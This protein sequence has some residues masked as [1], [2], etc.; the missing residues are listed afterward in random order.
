MSLNLKMKPSFSAPLFASVL[1]LLVLASDF[2]RKSLI[3]AGG[4][5]YLSVIIVQ[6]LIFIIPS[7]VFCRL[8]GVGYAS[9]LNIRLISPNKLG[10][11][12]TATLVLIFGSMLIR[13][14]QIYLF[15]MSSFTYSVFQ[16]YVGAGT[17]YNFLFAATAF[18]V[19]PALTE[20]FAFR[21]IILTEYNEGGYGA[22]NATVISSLLCS[23]LFFSLESLPIRF[24]TSL[25]F[26][27]L[28]YVTGSSL[29]SLICH[30]CFNIYSVFGEK[31]IIKALSDPSN[32]VI[33]IFTFALLFLILAVIMFG[34]FEHTLRQTG[35]N[36]T[37]SPSYLLKK[38]D[39]GETPDIAATESE[40]EKAL[41]KSVISEKTKLSIEA[42]FSPSFLICILI[43]AVAVIGLF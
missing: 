42:Y 32:K 24:F 16:D 35:R 13:F 28:T 38:S 12:I 34:E 36:G 25:V 23:M 40:E 31:Y 33:S 21:A 29:S 6:L 20:G 8:R 11:I 5:E 26:C 30:L 19:L 3:D 17:E 27:M 39:D 4:N 22:V 9:K 1:Y 41:S 2:F 14:A 18:A 37:P 43:F 7:I 10:S 15:G